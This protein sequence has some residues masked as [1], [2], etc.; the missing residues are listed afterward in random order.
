MQLPVAIIAFIAPTLAYATGGVSWQ[1]PGASPDTGLQDVSFGINMD[2]SP[3]DDGWYYAQQYGF[4]DNPNI[5]YTG[6]QP[7]KDNDEGQSIVHAVFSSFQAGTTTASPK[8]PKDPKEAVLGQGC[9]HYGADGGAGVSCYVD[10]PG[11]YS[12]TYNLTI[13]RSG[14]AD[15]RTWLGQVVDA[16]TGVVL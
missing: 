14:A 10:F 2:G 6:L 15:N 4:L 7:R 13:E 1:F 9:C 5:G 11:D 16:T 3:H 8:C 12:H